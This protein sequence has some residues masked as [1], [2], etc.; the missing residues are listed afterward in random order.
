MKVF[1]L[2]IRIGMHTGPC[3]A[4]VV[5]TRMPRFKRISFD[6]T[7]IQIHTIQPLSPKNP[8]HQHH[9]DRDPIEGI[10]CSATRWT[11]RAEWRAM[12][13]LLESTSVKPRNRFVAASQSMYNKQCC[14]VNTFP[15]L[16][17][18]IAM[19]IQLLAEFPGFQLEERG[20]MEIK[21]KGK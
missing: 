3:V 21:G 15:F 8:S 14:P 1:H 6:F 4:G 20:E 18:C 7:L 2:K 16:I 11:R 13:F 5:G 10:V 9:C 19:Y 12:V 17:Q